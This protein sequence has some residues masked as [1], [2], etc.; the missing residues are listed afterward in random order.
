M[1]L[2]WGR[3]RG[4]VGRGWP[5][6]LQPSRAAGREQ[7]WGWWGGQA[8][9][10]R[11]CS[12]GLSAVESGVSL[13]TSHHHRQA[14]RASWGVLAQALVEQPRGVVTTSSLWSPPRCYG[15][16]LV[17]TVTTSLLWPPLEAVVQLLPK[18][19]PPGLREPP[20]P[21]AV[22]ALVVLVLGMGGCW[23]SA[24]SGL[25]GGVFFQRGSRGW[26]WPVTSSTG[27]CA[28]AS[29]AACWRW[30]SSS[31]AVGA[32]LAREVPHKDI[33]AREGLG[34]V[35]GSRPGQ[36]ICGEVVALGVSVPAPPVGAG[37]T[38]MGC[39]GQGDRA[40]VSSRSCVSFL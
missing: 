37:G 30:C 15:H 26:L 35:P 28:P 2:L 33:P 19:S 32:V 1:G 22:L 34:W 7:G 16:H 5:A 12:A 27:V 38:Q 13:E 10:G 18:G 20:L 21:W 6:G 40:A 14:P 25:P 11:L 17:V 8:P 3:W 24:V 31:E 23:G 4:A 36:S 9:P 29:G 39:G